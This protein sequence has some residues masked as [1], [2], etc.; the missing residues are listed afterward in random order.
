MIADVMAVLGRA[1]EDADLG[2]LVE[3]LLATLDARP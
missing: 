3:G 1:T 2:T